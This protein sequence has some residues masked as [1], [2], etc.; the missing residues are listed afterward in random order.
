MSGKLLHEDA[1]AS[2]YTTGCQL[3]APLQ[4]RPEEASLKQGALQAF[5]CGALDAESVRGP[6]AVLLRGPDH[7]L[8]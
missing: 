4:V 2:K 1:P 7:E 5:S 8:L 3:A 6:I